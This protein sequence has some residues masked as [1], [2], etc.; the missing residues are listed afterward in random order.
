MNADIRSV[1]KEQVKE[2]KKYK[3]QKLINIGGIGFEKH[4]NFNYFF[5]SCVR[6]TFICNRY[7][8]QFHNLN[9]NKNGMQVLD[10]K[11]WTLDL[12]VTNTKFTVDV[13]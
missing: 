11:Y 9:Y 5:E 3:T 13:N 8:T 1:V 7:E 12:F 4:Y 6:K 10:L 2:K